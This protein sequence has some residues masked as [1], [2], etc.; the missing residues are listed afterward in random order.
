MIKPAPVVCGHL[1]PDQIW[2][3]RMN[4]LPTLAYRLPEAAQLL[5]VSR[6][7]LWRRIAAGQIPTRKI[8]NVTIIPAD[9]IREL[10]STPT[11]TPTIDTGS[12]A[13]RSDTVELRTRLSHRKQGLG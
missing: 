8:G 11:N 1:H 5:K 2:M 3:C 6:T 10:T 7:T 13:T 9:A 4:E 12:V